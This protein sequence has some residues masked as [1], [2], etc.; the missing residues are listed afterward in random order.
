[1][2]DMA[3]LL[4][5]LDEAH[6]ELAIGLEGCSTEDLWRRPHPRMLSIGEIAG[7]VGF[8]E[9]LWLLGHDW[10]ADLAALPIQSPL[11]DERFRYYPSSLETPVALELSAEEVTAELA[12]IHAAARPEAERRP[13]ETPVGEPWRNWGNMIQYQAFHIAYHTGQ[14]FVTR[15]MMGHETEDN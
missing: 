2:A 4:D 15:H 11:I 14:I 12:R 3:T 13:A 10:K 8:A 5:A 9:A 7:H 1:M 6:R